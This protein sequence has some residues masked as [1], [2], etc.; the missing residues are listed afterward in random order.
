MQI[1]FWF[2]NLKVEDTDL[3]FD[4]FSQDEEDHTICCNY[5]TIGQCLIGDGICL[6]P[7]KLFELEESIT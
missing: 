7:F 2:F 5:S 6:K 3:V 4:T 1:F